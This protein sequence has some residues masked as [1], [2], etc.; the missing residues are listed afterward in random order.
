MRRMRRAASAL[1]GHQGMLMGHALAF[2]A[3]WACGGD[4]NGVDLARVAALQP[5]AEFRVGSDLFA[6]YCAACHGKNATGTEAGPPLVHDYYKP[7]H[8][9]DAAF[10]LAAE[11]GVA[12]HH[13][14]FGN[15]PA[16][17]G[18]SAEDVGR[19]TAFVRWAQREG[20][21]K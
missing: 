4:Q 18:V 19:I 7:S 6:A 14:R 10:L 17:S 8:H 3:L 5:P 2:G 15:M 16:V 1:L 21:I 9:G 13:W 12:A 20:G 11:R